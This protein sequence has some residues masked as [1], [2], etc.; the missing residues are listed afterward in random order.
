FHFC[1]SSC[2]KCLICFALTSFRAVL[3][4]SYNPFNVKCLTL[5]ALSFLVSLTA[6]RNNSSDVV[7]NADA[8]EFPYTELNLVDTKDFNFS[9]PQHSNWSVAGKVFADRNLHH[10]LDVSPGSGIL[11]NK[12][13]S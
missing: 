4:S 7:D 5:F 12:P 13:D 3:S 8:E 6:C 10:G 11:A 2:C 1:G 9:N